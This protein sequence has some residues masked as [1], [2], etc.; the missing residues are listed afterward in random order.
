MGDLCEVVNRASATNDVS[1][2]W[3]GIKK[4]FQKFPTYSIPKGPEVKSASVTG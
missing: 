4:K 1:N 2:T 3:K